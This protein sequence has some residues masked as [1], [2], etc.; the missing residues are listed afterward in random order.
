MLARRS[1]WRR[2]APLRTPPTTSKLVSSLGPLL[3]ET[4]R[5]L[6]DAATSSDRVPASGGVAER[7]TGYLTLMDTPRNDGTA[8]SPQFDERGAVG[9]RAGRRCVAVYR[10]AGARLRSVDDERCSSPPVAGLSAPANDS[11]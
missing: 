10:P 5:T 2:S 3:K 6:V 11:R 8:G 9:D 7:P 4:L 1:R